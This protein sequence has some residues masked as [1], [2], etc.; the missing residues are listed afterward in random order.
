MQQIKLFKGI[1]NELAALEDEINTWLVE[2]E[3]TVLNIFGNIA[4]QTPSGAA[5]ATGLSK[6]EFPPSDVLIAILYDRVK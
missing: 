3:A 2:S 5:H 6:S 1:E 4:P